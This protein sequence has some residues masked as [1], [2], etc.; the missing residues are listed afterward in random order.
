ME[1][2]YKYS[3]TKRVTKFAVISG[4]IGDINLKLRDVTN[5]NDESSE[6]HVASEVAVIRRGKV[7]NFAE[8][9][10]EIAEYCLHDLEGTYYMDEKST[11]LAHV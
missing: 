8:A 3:Y 11:V 4:E 9:L 6:Y 10:N 7:Y 2:L 5:H 1:Y